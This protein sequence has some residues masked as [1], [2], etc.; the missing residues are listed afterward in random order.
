MFFYKYM[1]IN[2]GF[3]PIAI[4]LIIIAV[5]AVGGVAYFAGKSSNTLPPNVVPDNYQSSGN[6]NNI[7]TPPVQNTQVNNPVPN[8]QADCLPTT[9]PWIKVLSPNGGETYTMGQSITIT[10]KTCNA[11]SGQT[12]ELGIGKEIPASQ[13]NGISGAFN[14]EVSFYPYQI[15][16]DGTKTV[17][18]SGSSTNGNWPFTPGNNYKIS[19]VLNPLPTNTH[20]TPYVVDLSDNLFTINAKSVVSDCLPT[21]APWIK[22]LS[23]AGG[24]IY[25]VGQQV[26]VRWTSCNVQNIWLGLMSGGKDF[27]EMTDPNP[28]PSSQGSYQWIVSNPGRAFTQS[29]VNSYQI[30]VESQSPN[31][32]VKSEIFSVK[33]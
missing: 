4:V 33:Q 12:I 16:N 13:N 23:P 5:L 28:V 14:P 30:G 21:T 17:T 1:K 2:K 19:A 8:T 24:E 15:T 27:G 20:E 31:V 32:L 29:D 25:T 7:A 11:Q 18:L 6:Q 9:A 10:W 26:A 22:V 3:A